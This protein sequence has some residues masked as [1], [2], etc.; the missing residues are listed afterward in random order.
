MKL[1][2][3][4]YMK[5][6]KEFIGEDTSETA[7]QFLEDTTDTFDGLD[8]PANNENYV[9]KQE[10]DNLNETWAKKYKERFFDGGDESDPPDIKKRSHEERKSF[11]DLFETK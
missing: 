4:E 9:T 11:E 3:D 7:I 8:D 5:R 10:Y 6:L 2:K 1:S